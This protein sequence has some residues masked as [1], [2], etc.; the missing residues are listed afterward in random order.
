MGHMLAV[1]AIKMLPSGASG[2]TQPLLPADDVEK[3]S[4]GG[5]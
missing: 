4:G 1:A 3:D 5:V 2:E